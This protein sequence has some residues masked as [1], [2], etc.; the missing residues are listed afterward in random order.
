MNTAQRISNSPVVLTLLKDITPLKGRRL[1]TSSVS[2]NVVYALAE[3]DRPGVYLVDTATGEQALEI[4]SIEKDLFFS[5]DGR[6]FRKEQVAG[7][8]SSR[9]EVKDGRP[10]D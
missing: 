1:K 3:G 7:W 10:D 5:A 2:E 6:A 4:L 9:I 8:I